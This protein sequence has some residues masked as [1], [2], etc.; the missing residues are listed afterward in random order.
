MARFGK[1][2]K[3][4]AGTESMPRS[5][6][7]SMNEAENPNAPPPGQQS[8]E[9]PQQLYE[10]PRASKGSQEK[11]SKLQKETDEV[12][13]V[14]RGNVDQMLARGESMQDLSK[15]TENLQ[16]SSQAF[17]SKA[18]AV[19]KKLWWKNF[20]TILIVA[21]IVLLIVLVIFFRFFFSR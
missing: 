4:G 21:M 10:G 1:H 2:K 13:N 17:A 5:P 7:E 8:S 11:I 16:T 14:M 18:A 15:Q 9:P 20:R 3:K 6:K 19:K 12:T